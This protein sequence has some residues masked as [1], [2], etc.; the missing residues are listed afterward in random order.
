MAGCIGQESNLLLGFHAFRWNISEGSM[1]HVASWSYRQ[2]PNPNKS[3]DSRESGERRNQSPS[4]GCPPSQAIV[5]TRNFTFWQQKLN[6]RLPLVLERE[7]S[8]SQVSYSF[9]AASSPNS[10]ATYPTRH[11]VLDWLFICAA[12]GAIGGQ[13]CLSIM[14][15]QKQQPPPTINHPFKQVSKGTPSHPKFLLWSS[16]E[17]KKGWQQKSGEI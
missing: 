4:L 3:I 16:L 10:A 1:N 7:T 15:L 6:L 5:T 13:R 12:A 8:Q 2:L 17:E 14:Q 11:W 9:L